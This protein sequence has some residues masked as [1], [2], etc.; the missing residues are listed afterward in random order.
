V[1]RDWRHILLRHYRPE[2][3]LRVP[4]HEIKRASVPVIDVHNHLGLRTDPNI[5]WDPT[6]E[7]RWAVA[8]VGRL[9]DQMDEWNVQT[10]VNLDGYWGDKLEANLNHYDRSHPGRFATFCRLDWEKCTQPGWPEKLAKSLRESATR[11]AIGLK[12]WKNL[13]LRVRDTN[14]QLLQPDDARLAPIWQAAHETKLP[15]LIH[16]AD[17]PAFF[18]PISEQNERLEELVAHPEWHY[19][20]AKFP[21]FQALLD[22][23]ERLVAQ[24]PGVT[25]IGAHV[26]GNAENLA[27]VAQM[28]NSYPNFYVDVAARLADLGRQ[29]RAA[30]RLILAHPTRVLFGTDASPP[31]ND[32]FERHFRFFETDDE[33]FAYAGSDPPSSGRWTISGIVLPPDVLANVYALNAQRIVPAL[34]TI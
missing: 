27:W 11:G 24:N 7:D 30:R 2:P 8:D 28:L 16:V 14:G 31:T 6:K 5:L 23:L 32:A 15:V 9:V 33:C 34:R 19:A 10:I 22:T 1:E 17:P 3:M 20:D 21:R 25:F 18:E 13:G 4:A 26:G 12:I 29:P